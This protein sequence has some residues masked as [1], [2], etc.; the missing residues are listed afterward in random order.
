MIKK[1]FSILLIS[2]LFCS[3]FSVKPKDFTYLY[4]GQNTG[5]AAQIDINGCYIFQRECDSSFF[6]VVMFY[7]D[8]LFTIATA[9]NIEDIIVCFGSNERST[10]CSYPSW[11][12][13]RLVGD[14]I[15]T[16]TIIDESMPVT[17]IFRDYLILSNKSIINLSDYVNSENTPIGYMKNYPSFK[18]NKCT[19]PATFHL[20]KNKRSYYFCPYLNKKWFR[21]TIDK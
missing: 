16:Q 11:G 10:V 4:N 21:Y 19:Q 8:G 18:N 17:T 3:C 1:L 2:A 14:T 12:T 5:L 20:L 7:P 13:Y 15:K 6:S 9:T